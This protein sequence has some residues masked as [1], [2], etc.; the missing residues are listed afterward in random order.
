[1]FSGVGKSTA[2]AFG[3]KRREIEAKDIIGI[4]FVPT[5]MAGGVN[6]KIRVLG[7]LGLTEIIFMKKHEKDAI[8]LTMRLEEL[9][10]Q[11]K[12]VAAGGELQRGGSEKQGKSEEELSLMSPEDRY[13]LEAKSKAKASKLTASFGGLMLY[14]D[15]ITKGLGSSWPLLGAEAEVT[16]GSPKTRITA[17]RVVAIGVFALLAKKNATK[18]FLEVETTTGPVVIEFDSKKEKDARQF[19]M[20]LNRAAGLLAKV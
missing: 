20:K 3:A 6:G 15:K 9:A 5:T 12:G 14:T 7:P 11:A 10:P 8:S 18:G 19:A 1:V 4:E 13:L 17:T 2:Q 16:M